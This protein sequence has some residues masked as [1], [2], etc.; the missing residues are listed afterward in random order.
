MAIKKANDQAIQ[1]ARRLFKEE[2]P[3]LGQPVLVM[4]NKTEWP[5]EGQI[6]TA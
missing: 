6:S 3:S 2:A 4:R 5:E 1:T